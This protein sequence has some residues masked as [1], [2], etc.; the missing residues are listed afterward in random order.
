MPA[1]VNLATTTL[2][3]TLDAKSQFVK[4]A[5]TSGVRPGMCLFLD[6]E[7][8]KV[9][10]LDVDPWVRV[11][12]GQDGSKA[13]T[14][15]SGVAV[16]AGDGG[17]FYQY[18]PVG[19]PPETFEVSPWINVQNG[20]VWF[21]QGDNDPVGLADRWWQLQTTSYDQGPLGIR[22]KTLNPASST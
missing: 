13:I 16:Y 6:G 17:Q 22:V 11:L 2:A 4:L 5:S 1:R 18:D 19:R 15:S 9:I 10:S 7:L 3:A 21:A 20:A 8:T 14:H 12:R